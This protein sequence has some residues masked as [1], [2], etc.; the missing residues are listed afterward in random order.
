VISITKAGE[1]T[2]DAARHDRTARLAAS[3]ALLEPEDAAA[4]LAAMP[5]LESLA[6]HIAGKAT[7]NSPVSRPAADSRR[8]RG[9]TAYDPRNPQRKLATLTGGRA[10][11]GSRASPRVP[12][13]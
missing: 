2:L 6:D 12:R 4:L 9:P 8:G 1:A 10:G 5:A 13:A 3:L 11:A 7:T